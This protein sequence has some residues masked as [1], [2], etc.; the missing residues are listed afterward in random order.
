[1]QNADDAKSANEWARIYGTELWPWVIAAG[2]QEVYLGAI[3]VRSITP[4]AV[5]LMVNEINFQC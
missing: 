4:H 2:G 1:M 3:P 5:M